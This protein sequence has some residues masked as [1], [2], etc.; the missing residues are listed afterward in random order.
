M[1]VWAAIPSAISKLILAL[2]VGD[3][4]LDTL[5]PA[6]QVQVWHSG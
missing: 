3:R 5:A 1:L 6:L 2:E 4:S